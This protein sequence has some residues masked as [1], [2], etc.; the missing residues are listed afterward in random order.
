MTNE[1]IVLDNI[2]LLMNAKGWSLRTLATQSS[3]S[4]GNLSKILQGSVK[5][6]LPAAFKIAEAL[7]VDFQD[8]LL[9]GVKTYSKEEAELK[10]YSIGIVS[11]NN[12]R[13]TSILDHNGNKVSESTLSRGLDLADESADLIQLVQE[14]INDAWVKINSVS[15]LNPSEIKLNLVMQSYEFEEKRKRFLRLTHKYFND[16]TIL[17]DWV[18]TLLATFDG[19]EGISLIVDKGVSLSYLYDNYLRKIGG[20][21]Y[22]VYDLGGENWLGVETIKH[23][24]EAVEGYVPMSDLAH[25]VIS[26]FNGK[27]DYITE[28]CHLSNDADIYC[29]FSEMLLRAYY[30]S[31]TMAKQIVR[32]GANH[33]KQMI[34]LVDQRT[35]NQLQITLNGSLRE[36]YTPYLDSNRIFDIT[37]TNKDL[38]EL[39]AQIN[40][41]RLNLYHFN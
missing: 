18:V 23:T 11:I 25:N 33:I 12:R 2:K 10:K 39:L 4:P 34:A 26:K 35:N 17:P 15:S 36:L 6:S 41:E 32:A 5:L 8:K 28:T 31:E 29:V 1:E 20:W 30:T 7:D 16:V 21:K 19:A 24:I 22:P 13:L 14:A 3:M 40:D 27:I 37:S 9:K 38:S